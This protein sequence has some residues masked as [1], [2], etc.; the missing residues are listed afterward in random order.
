M[1]LGVFGMFLGVFGCFFGVFVV[2]LK[3]ILGCFAD[4]CWVVLG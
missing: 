4:V 3:H 2:F 1:H